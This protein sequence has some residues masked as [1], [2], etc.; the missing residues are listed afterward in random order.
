[1][2]QGGTSLLVTRVATGSFAPATSDNV[3]NAL[4]SGVISTNADDLLTSLAAVT[5]SAGT[6]TISGSSGGSGTGFV[7]SIT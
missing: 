5:G 7:A 3:Q 6:Y 1:M 4:E 2:A